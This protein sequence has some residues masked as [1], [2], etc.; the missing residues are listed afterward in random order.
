[1]SVW[2]VTDNFDRGVRDRVYKIERD[3]FANYPGVKFDF[4]VIRNCEGA[5]ISDAELVYVRG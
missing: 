5:D 2:T 4:R 1:M 3:M